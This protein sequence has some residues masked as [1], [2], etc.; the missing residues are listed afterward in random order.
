M[1]W[2]VEVGSKPAA[3][4]VMRAFRFWLMESSIVPRDIRRKSRD[5]WGF[6]IY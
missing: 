6:S 5:G 4:G 2:E 1:R 3:A